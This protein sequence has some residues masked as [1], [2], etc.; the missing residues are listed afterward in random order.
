MNQKNPHSKI[1]VLAVLSVSVMIT[2]GTAIS[3][4]LPEM[5]KSFPNISVSQ[6][7]MIA[8]I[9]QFSVMITLLLSGFISKKLGIKRTITIGL[10]LTGVAG[11]FPFFSH[12]FILILISRLIVGCGIGLFNSLA[13]TIIDLFYEDP[14]RSQMLGFRSATEQI[15]VS[16]LNIVVGLLVLINWH[17]SFLIYLLAFPLL[18]FFLKVVP[19]PPIPQGSG[20]GKQR[21]NLPVLIM[22]VLLAF[23]VACTTAV[24]IQ[25][26]NIIVTD[27]SKSSAVSSLI[28]SANTLMGMVMG[29]LFGRIYRFVKKFILPL[30]I[31][32]MALGSLIMVSFHSVFGVTLGAVV[33]GMSYP[34]VGSYIFSLVSVIA[35]K[36]SE[37]LANSTLLIGANL[38]SFSTPLFLSELG[39]MNS[40][41]THAGP[42]LTAFWLLI[43]L[44]MIVLI[45]QTFFQK[46]VHQ[47]IMN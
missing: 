45:Y 20:N 37:T 16:I 27:L 13:I 35:P 11:V 44:T 41:T 31:L 34:L 22:T 17:A 32:F 43:I 10:I 30:G 21:I 3:S 47:N 12:S 38:G 9:Q 8:T 40:L 6:I 23:M 15:G 2:T 42:F 36:G 25:V 29:I 24:V 46:K 14:T 19:E 5:A 18:A 26:P 4:A 39:K 1:F 33:C 7:D 28:I